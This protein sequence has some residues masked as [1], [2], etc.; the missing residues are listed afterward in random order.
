M[1]TQDVLSRLMQA[2]SNRL[3]ATNTPT[4]DHSRDA[5]G[6]D[7]ACHNCGSDAESVERCPVVPTETQGDGNEIALC[8]ECIE[9]TPVLADPAGTPD[10]L[11]GT[12]GS[13]GGFRTCASMNYPIEPAHVRERDGQTC[14]GCGVREALVVGDDLHVH[15]VVPIENGGYRHPHNFVA[16]C[17]LCHRAVHE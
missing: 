2:T 15:P 11:A 3:P 8:P 14:R 13:D 9:R 7:G 10:A 4:G 12:N 1:Q 16:L 5:I 6:L 17:P